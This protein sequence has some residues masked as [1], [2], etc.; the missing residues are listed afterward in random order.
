MENLSAALKEA[1]NKCIGLF[2]YKNI[3]P[4]LVIEID[5]D[6]LTSRLG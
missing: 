6:L 2:K 1:Q 5:G 4:W 3:E